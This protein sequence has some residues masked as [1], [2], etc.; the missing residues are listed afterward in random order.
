[1]VFAHKDSWKNRPMPRETRDLA[2]SAEFSTEEFER[3]SRGLI[4]RTM[5]DKWFV[6]LQESILHFHRSWTGICIYQVEI[7]RKDEGY[8]V[9]RARVNRDES[10][11]QGD[12]DAHDAKLLHFL[13][14]NLLLDW[15]TA[16]PLPAGL[17][18]ELPEGAYQHHVAGTA[19][20]EE[21]AGEDS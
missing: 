8:F 20:R 4:P 16:F 10:E 5:D 19:Y 15:D 3:I 13:I 2:Y 18:D 12:D 9:S 17:P 7:T 14:S 6:Y 11:Y 21:P 1:M